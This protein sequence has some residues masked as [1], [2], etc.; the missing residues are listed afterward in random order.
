MFTCY[1]LKVFVLQEFFQYYSESN[2]SRSSTDEE[3]KMDFLK[4]GNVQRLSD[5]ISD[6]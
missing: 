3:N 2:G 6:I 4:P 1:K 5:A